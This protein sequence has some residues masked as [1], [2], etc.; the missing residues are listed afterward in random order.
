MAGHGPAPKDPEQRRNHAAPRRG[1]WVDLPAT[2][3]KRAPAMPTA[4]RGGWAVG[5]RKAWKLWW[6]DPASLMWSPADLASV[7]QLAA[8]HHDVERGKSSLAGE[9]R[10]RLDGLGLTAKGKRDLRWRIVEPEVEEQRPSG[11]KSS[12]RDHLRVVGQ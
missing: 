5:T 6:M 8:L 12:R 11:R 1:E 9:V 2:N 7:A 3:E 10:L 4:P